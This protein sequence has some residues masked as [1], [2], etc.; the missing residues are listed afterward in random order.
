[1]TTCR[2]YLV[3]GHFPE[4]K[5]LRTAKLMKGYIAISSRVGINKAINRSTLKSERGEM[6]PCCYITIL[7]PSFDYDKL[8]LYIYAPRCTLPF[9]VLIPQHLCVC[10]SRRHRNMVDNNLVRSMHSHAVYATFGVILVAIFGA[11]YHPDAPTS[12]TYSICFYCLFF[13]L[14]LFRF[15]LDLANANIFSEIDL[16]DYTIFYRTQPGSYWLQEFVM[17]AGLVTVFVCKW[18]S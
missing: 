16:R 8:K 1:M 5:T 6:A 14:W 17:T 7:V 9:R 4:S 13:G 2:T 12:Y 18:I 15:V 3:N 10:K 11:S